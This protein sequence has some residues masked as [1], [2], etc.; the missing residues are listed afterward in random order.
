MGRISDIIVKVR[1][2]LADTSGDRWSDDRLLRLIDDA[3][4]DICRHGKLLR[5]KADIDIFSLEAIAPLPDD[6]LLLDRVL[7]QG[8]I[9]PL[10]SHLYMD[11]LSDNWEADISN[12]IT[13]IIFDKQSRHSIKLY[14]IPEV[15]GIEVYDID[16][17]YGV[18]SEI[19]G[20]TNSDEYGVLATLTSGGTTETFNS[21]YGITT[22]ISETSEALTIYY[23]RKPV[24]VTLINQELEI[25]D[26]FDSAIKYYVT[27]KALRDDMDTQNRVVGNEELSFYE[28][29]LTEAIKDSTMD[30]TQ[31]SNKQ[32]SAR[33]KGAFDE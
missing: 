28:R 20:L 32:Y 25:D 30:Y 15:V 6:L 5:T 21:V 4:K 1:D 11:N 10:V 13:K 19:S 33:Y 12:K 17:E 24:K 26:V 9:L 3:Q 23:I 7:Y 14:P 2:T 16:S 18:V 8:E 22:D 27:G 29:E 31:S